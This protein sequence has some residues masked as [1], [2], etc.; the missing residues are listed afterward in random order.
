MCSLCTKNNGIPTNIAFAGMVY[1]NLPLCAQCLIICT[2]TY[3]HPTLAT[4]IH[5]RLK[6]VCENA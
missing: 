6:L 5:E 2:L 4:Q 3:R 1:Y